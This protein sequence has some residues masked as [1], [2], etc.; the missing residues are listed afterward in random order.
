[1]PFLQLPALKLYY[2]IDG[3]GPPLM[4]VHGLGSSSRDWEKQVPCFVEKYKVIALDLRGHGRSDK[5]PGPYSMRTFAEDTAA[6]IRELKQAP[7]HLVGIS[8]G[9]MVGFE[10]AV[11]FPELL[12][13]L[14]I[15]NSYPEMRVETLWEHL[16]VWRRYLFLELLGM[17]GTGMML[18]R[19]LFP[20][21]EQA[22]LRELF[23]QRWAE[24]DKRAYR[25]SLRAIFNWDV[26]G[27]LGEIKC[28]VLVVASDQ[29]YM[30][31]EEK[32][33]YTAKMPNAKLAVIEDARHAVTA[34]R[35]EQFNVVL[36]EFL[37]SVTE[38]QGHREFN[39]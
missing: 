35:P 17:R 31:L 28:P 11:R 39:F 2:E 10:L 33:A 21:P 27:H 29:D 18:G 37:A 5:P 25:E 8:M 24:N 20:S 32:R 38:T 4:L 22:E 14:T 3:E 30:P 9:G 12:R 26:E 36:E 13:S 23:V 1:M 16:Q 19:H 6:L 15:V 34:E 7:L